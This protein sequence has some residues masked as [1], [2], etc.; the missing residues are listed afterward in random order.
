MPTVQRPSVV[1]AS[2]SAEASTANQS[3]PTSTAV[4]QQPEQAMEAPTATWR[5]GQ[6]AGGVSMTRRMSWPCADRVDGSDT[7]RAR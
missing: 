1:W 5:F 6:D 3:A 7:C 2:V 4:R